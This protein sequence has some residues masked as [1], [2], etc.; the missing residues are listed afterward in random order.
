MT[1]EQYINF[2]EAIK[3]VLA[4][5]A[6]NGVTQLDEA[7]EAKLGGFGMRTFDKSAGYR[8]EFDVRSGAHINTWCHSKHG[9]HCAF[10]GN[11]KAV[12][13]I[14]RLLFYWDTKLIRRTVE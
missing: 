13:S 2:G 5:L 10:P 3:R 7:Y 14:W 8:I 9:P 11:E 6:E 4:W 12:K 1:I